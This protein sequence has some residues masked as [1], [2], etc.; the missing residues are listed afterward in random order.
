VTYPYTEK[1]PMDEIE[2]QRELQTKH[3]PVEI[4]RNHSVGVWVV[5]RKGLREYAPG[6]VEGV[7]GDAT[8]AGALLAEKLPRPWHYVCDR[9][10]PACNEPCVLW[11]VPEEGSG[12]PPLLIP[13][14]YDPVEE[15][16]LEWWDGIGE[17]F[18][19]GASPGDVYAWEPEPE[20]PPIP[21]AGAV[22]DPDG[23]L[24]GMGRL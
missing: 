8:V 4:G 11:V 3:G 12:L 16:G 9:S 19:S 23:A 24:K 15:D 13:G 6:E 22:A 2:W 21:E 1:G 18:R 17:R 5:R 14:T 20:P 10:R 7:F